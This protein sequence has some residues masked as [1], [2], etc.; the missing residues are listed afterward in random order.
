MAR[1]TNLTKGSGDHM[2]GAKTTYGVPGLGEKDAAEV[3]GILQE[4]LNA[5]N[6]L[7][8][9]L[10]N[11]HWNVVGPHFIT[12]H[13]MLDPQVT[14]RLEGPTAAGGGAFAVSR[15]TLPRR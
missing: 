2:A 3:T 1:T 13:T 15:R 6:D 10:K 5:L 9:T 11:I 14:V 7:A 8:L 12:V 4:R